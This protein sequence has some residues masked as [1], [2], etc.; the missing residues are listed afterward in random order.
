MF[1][2]EIEVQR[3]MPTNMTGEE[4]IYECMS[5]WSFSAWNSK[6]SSPINILR[7]LLG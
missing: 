6:K 3:S 1:C 5:E 7:R 4:F 2:Y